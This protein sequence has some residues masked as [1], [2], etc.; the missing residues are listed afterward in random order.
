MPEIESRSFTGKDKEELNDLYNLVAGRSRTVRQFEWE[1]LNT[2]EGWGSMWLLEDMDRS[3]IIGHHGLIPVR[4]SYYGRDILAGKTENTV[5]HPDYRGKGIYYP[6]EVKFHE[7]AKERFQLL[8]TTAGVLE[9]GSIRLKLGYANV[10]GYV[11]YVRVVKSVYLHKWLAG[12][13]RSKGY[14]RFVVTL[15]AIASRVSGVFAMP[16]FLKRSY[17]DKAV[18]L[19]RITDIGTVSDELDRFWD[20]NRDKFG[21]TADRNSRYLKWRIFENPNLEYDFYI[22]RRQGDVVGYA[23]LKLSGEAGA[24]MGSVVDLVADDNNQVLFNSIMAGVESELKENGVYAIHFF[25][26]SSDNAL[27][28]ALKR[29]GFVSLSRLE[30]IVR[31]ITKER[32][33]RLMAKAIGNNV[34]QAKV[35]DPACWYFTDML[36]EGVRS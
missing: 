13:V 14:N 21:I 7:E 5:M 2:P 10:G 9:Q 24:Q 36:M 17:I 33:E 35:A 19:E 3:K 15:I 30:G 8:F 6:F 16:F 27:N 23:I 32:A 12:I 20:R 22:A 29:N 34:D 28:R 1:W 31:R 26:L 18:K 4:F 25:T 11:N